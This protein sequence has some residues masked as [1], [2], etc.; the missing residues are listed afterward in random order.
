MANHEIIYPN[1][2]TSGVEK[3]KT[4]DKVHADVYNK[5]INILLNN[6]VF[7]NTFMEKLTKATSEHMDD[8]TQHV[9][10]EEK[11]AWSNKAE[12]VL[13]TKESNG[14]LS[15]ALFEKLE[16]VKDG[17]QPNQ[18]A[19]TNVKAGGITVVANG[20][21]STFELVPGTSITLDADNSTK[22]ITINAPESIKNPNSLAVQV[23]GKNIASYNGDVAKTVN[24]TK[25]SLGLENLSNVPDSEKSVKYAESAGSA[26]EARKWKTARKISLS[27]DATGNVT[28]DGLE[29]VVLALTL[30]ASGVAAG[31]YGPTANASPG[32]AGTIAIPQLTVDAKGRVTGVTART[33]T[34]PTAPTSVSGNAGSVAASGVQAGVLPAGVVATNDIDYTTPRL[35]NIRFGLDIPT[36]LNNG[37]LY[38]VYE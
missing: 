4:T 38:G 7:L 31:A 27:G 25:V 10:N 21:T 13:A 11:Q 19:F 1:E 5:I 23:E 26:D 37:E 36:S 34:L 20:E 18:N 32:F 15:A 33:I 3:F 12:N 6:E 35:R 2:F 24:I 22:K 16:G 30:A 9:S 17:A 14:L 8:G 29:D 28:I